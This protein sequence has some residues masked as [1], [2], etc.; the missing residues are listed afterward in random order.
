VQYVLLP[1]PS[2]PRTRPQE[3]TTALEQRDRGERANGEL[4]TR[5]REAVVDVVRRQAEAG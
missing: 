3:L 5:I 1:S 4:G 2:Q